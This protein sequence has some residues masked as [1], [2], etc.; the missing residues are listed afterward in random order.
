MKYSTSAFIATTA[1]LA[2]QEGANAQFG[3][4]PASIKSYANKYL[5]P[6]VQSNKEYLDS[7]CS[8]DDSGSDEPFL[9][10]SAPDDCNPTVR[11][12][13]NGE[14]YRSFSSQAKV[15]NGEGLMDAMYPKFVDMISSDYLKDFDESARAEWEKVSMDLLEADDEA[16]TFR[17]MG[18][19]SDNK[20]NFLTLVG[21]HNKETSKSDISIVSVG[22]KFGFAPDIFVVRKTI[23]DPKTGKSVT[24]DVIE[25]RASTK[26][27][28]VDQMV[29]FMEIIAFDKLTDGF[30]DLKLQTAAYDF[31]NEEC[32]LI[33]V[34][35][36]GGKAC[37]EACGCEWTEPKIARQVLN[38]TEFM[39][40]W[41]SYIAEVPI[42]K[43]GEKLSMDEEMKLQATF[44]P[45]LTGLVGAVNSVTSAWKG[46]VGAF[47]SSYSKELVDMKL[48]RGFDSFRSSMKA[49]AGEGMPHERTEEFLG[50]LSGRLA[51]PDSYRGDFEF[52]AKWVQF[53]DSQTWTQSDV[54][55][56][57]GNGGQ[58]SNFNFFA[59][60]RP[61]DGKMD[62]TYVTCGQD[63]TLADD[64][65]VWVTRKSTLGGLFSSTK[66]EIEKKPAAI[67]QEQLQFVSEWFLLLAYQELAR[68]MQIAV[69]G[70]G[71]NPVP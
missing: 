45:F 13:V 58:T 14:G 37:V 59:R 71:G 38:E 7:V 54:T 30:D 40:K 51:I 44:L 34:R 3:A 46:I 5:A 57:K 22:M 68:F 9:A 41:G 18:C 61:E 1:L 16:M 49:F 33:C 60:N 63:F 12:L 25:E 29:K 19:N 39:T 32:K 64:L 10:F 48:N 21:K 26:K 65:Y 28:D 47:A 62:I 55:F 70:D 20:C 17:T 42:A 8:V 31:C 36:G 4:V 56:K 27:A 15:N 69:P 67:T 24:S 35:N 11:Q 50:D 6:I 53:F 66:T 23:T 2:G 43:N 52:M